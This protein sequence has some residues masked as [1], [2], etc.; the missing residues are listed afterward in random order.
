MSCFVVVILSFISSF[1]SLSLKYCFKTFYDGLVIARQ[2]FIIKCVRVIT[3]TKALQKFKIAHG[4]M[5]FL[6]KRFL[7]SFHNGKVQLRIYS[8]EKRETTSA[9]YPSTIT[10]R[11]IFKNSFRR[12]LRRQRSDW[13][14]EKEDVQNIP[15]E[16]KFW[17]VAKQNWVKE[18]I[19]WRGKKFQTFS[20]MNK[21]EIPPRSTRQATNDALQKTK[22]RW[23]MFHSSQD[24]R[25]PAC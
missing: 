6:D 24:V 17:M 22:P 18:K 25:I 21:P 7:Q 14:K 3:W 8:C 16:V 13:K 15:N 23:W 12:K 19:F 5:T 10:N 9:N 4:Q 20:S 11:L 1:C 2:D